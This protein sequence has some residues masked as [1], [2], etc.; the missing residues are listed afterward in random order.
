MQIVQGEKDRTFFET[1]KEDCSTE[2]KKVNFCPKIY[3]RPIP[4]FQIQMVE[5]FI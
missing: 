5:Q 3:G 2:I 4:L 1:L